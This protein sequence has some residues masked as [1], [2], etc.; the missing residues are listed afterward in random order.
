MR[1]EIIYVF[2]DPGHL[3][4]FRVVE[5]FLLWSSTL[6]F[7]PSIIN[8]VATYTRI[9]RSNIRTSKP[10]VMSQGHKTKSWTMK[11]EK[12]TIL[13]IRSDDD[14]SCKTVWHNGTFSKESIN[15]TQDMMCAGWLA[16]GLGNCQVQLNGITFFSSYKPL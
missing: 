7:H 14:T 3:T 12:Q 13:K 11:K 1:W 16:G 9:L 2:V 5:W 4:L 15:V 6:L 10:Y 8:I